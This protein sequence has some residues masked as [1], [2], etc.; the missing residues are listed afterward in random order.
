[1]RERCLNASYLE[2]YYGCIAPKF[3]EIDIM[4]KSGTRQLLP[5]KVARVLDITEDELLRIMEEE[6]I[7]KL[8]RENFF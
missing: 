4:L 7:R 3:W 2:Y 8:T 1:M 5:S 6:G